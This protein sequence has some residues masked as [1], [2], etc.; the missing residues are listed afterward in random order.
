MYIYTTVH[1]LLSS[2]K[3]YKNSSWVSLEQLTERERQNTRRNHWC[4]FHYLLPN[5]CGVTPI[6]AFPCPPLQICFKFIP[7]SLWNSI[8]VYPSEPRALRFQVLYPQLAS[9]YF[10]CY[11]NHCNSEMGFFKISW[12][13]RK[14]QFFGVTNLHAAEFRHNFG[15]FH[16]I[17]KIPI[18]FSSEMSN[19]SHLPT[20]MQ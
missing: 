14:I 5:S 15:A 10:L 17:S 4:C 12:L 19:F 1:C 13:C 7:S 3:Q 18:E 6:E 8:V 16:E 11:W 9:F 2:T 20:C